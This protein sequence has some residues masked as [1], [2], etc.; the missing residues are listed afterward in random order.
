MQISFLRIPQWNRWRQFAGTVGVNASEIRGEIKE[1][2]Q[3]NK[4]L[5]KYVRILKLNAFEVEEMWIIDR[6]SFQN[7]LAFTFQSLGHFFLNL[8][9]ASAP[10]I[11]RSRRILQFPFT[12]RVKK[13]FNLEKWSNEADKIT[14]WKKIIFIHNQLY[15][16]FYLYIKIYS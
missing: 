13:L 4:H 5:T 8:Q 12:I 2:G 9:S 7:S 15:M 3:R 6:F 10:L 11:P 1:V 14:R 16:Y